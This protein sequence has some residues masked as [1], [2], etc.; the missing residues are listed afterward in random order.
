MAKKN[1][2]TRHPKYFGTE[3]RTLVFAVEQTLYH[4]P[5]A[6]LTMMSPPLTAIFGI[7][8]SSP[9][10]GEAAEGTETNP[11]V[12]PGVRCEE[13]D[14]FLSYFFKSEFIPL[15]QLCAERKEKLGVNLLKLGCLWDIQEVKTYAKGI[16]YSVALPP[17]R[18]LEIARAFAV[19]EWV[20]DCVKELIPLCGSFDTDTAL[21]IGTITLNIMFSA[22]SALDRERLFVAHTAP[23]LT[24]MDA[25]NYGD[26]R[27]HSNCERAIRE[28][29]W[30]LVGKKVLHPTNPMSVDAI[31]AHLSKITFPGMSPKC[32]E[33]M[34]AKWTMNVFQAEGVVRSA[35]EGVVAYNKVMRAS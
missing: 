16:L 30:A 19:H 25:L 26:C 13:F 9:T 11:V 32:Q 29:W 24:P 4:L 14:D 17:A 12:L 20:E 15:P 31:G 18:R 2:Y 33:E 1:E 5:L 6:V 7:P 27:N 23:K 10:P 22:K 28:G 3:T 35:V 21:Q 34:V 8:A